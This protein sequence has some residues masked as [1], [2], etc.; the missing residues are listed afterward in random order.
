[1][2]SHRHTPRSTPPERSRSSFLAGAVRRALRPPRPALC[3]GAGL[4][5]AGVAVGLDTIVPAAP[6]PAVF[7][8]SSLLPVNGGDGSA[9]FVLSGIDAYDRSGR[10]VS[11]GDVNGDGLG[12]VILGAPIADPG[13]RYSAGESYVVFG[14]YTARAG[15]F[16]AVFPLASL[17]PAAGGDGS[18]GFV[19]KGIDSG[20][21]SGRSV[22]AAGDVNG[23]ASAI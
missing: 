14:R 21:Y 9:G 11:A 4:L 23:M 22:S 13:G 20:D 12:D 2:P 17:L 7:E 16:P 3:L 1:M 15:S 6:F 5:A 19:L 10:S 18:A 8:L